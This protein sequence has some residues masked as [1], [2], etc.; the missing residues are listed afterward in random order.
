[1]ANVSAFPAPELPSTETSFSAWFAFFILL[2]L[3]QDYDAPLQS[4][5]NSESHFGI[6]EPFFLSEGGVAIDIDVKA[7]EI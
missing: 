1:M 3:C 2:E 6:T 4:I 7:K 5:L